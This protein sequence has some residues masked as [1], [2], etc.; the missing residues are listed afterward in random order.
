MRIVAPLALCLIILFSSCR[1]TRIKDHKEWESNFSK[2]GIKDGCFIIRDH[3]HEIIKYYNKDRCIQRYTPASTFKICNSLIALETAVAFDD[4]L[5]IKWDSV[6][7]R[8]EWDKDLNMR[9]AFQASSLPFFQEVA[10]RIG[11]AR[12]QHYIDTMQYGNLKMAGKIDDFWI[13]NSL[14]IS[15]DEQIGFLKRMYFYELPM[16]ERTQRIVKTMMLMEE[17]PEYKLY[18]K[19]GTHVD[20]DSTLY[21]VVGFVERIEHYKEHKNSMN[22][23]A[24]RNYPYFFALNFTQ[25]NADTSKNWFEAR[26]QLV[27][28]LL[29]QNDAIPKNNSK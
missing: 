11:P 9:A 13:N 15:A 14:Q 17:K 27:H 29:Q 18:Y 1:E 22:K 10:R 21:W 25:A 24:E 28:D 12:M 3:N 23:S 26:L 7:R 16:S 5:T 2:Y 20:K 19:T 4:Q 6:V 8:P